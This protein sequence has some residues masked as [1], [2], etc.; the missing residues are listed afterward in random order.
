MRER[1]LNLDSLKNVGGLSKEYADFLHQAASVCFDHNHHETGKEMFVE[2]KYDTSF[3]L[4]WRS[5]DPQYF[6]SWKDMQEATE[7]GAYGIAILLAISLTD[8]Q[9][10]ERS[11]KGTGFD[12]WLGFEADLFQ[13]SARLEVSG[14][15]AGN[16][17]DINSRVLKKRRQLIGADNGR[18]PA[19]IIIVE[20]STP[21]SNISLQ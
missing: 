18:L 1:T 11:A 3:F 17:V 5:L 13:R 20:F 4:I 14:I 9:C 8:Y 2:G 12:Y 6:P 19:Y 15:L 10:I 7:Y 21:K 16:Q